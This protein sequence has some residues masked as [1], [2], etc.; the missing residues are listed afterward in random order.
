[1]R[2]AK[3]ALGN[4]SDGKVLDGEF[5]KFG[6][7]RTEQ[8]FESFPGIHMAASVQLFHRLDIGG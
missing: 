6:A 2:R 8:R 3:V 7:Y 5:G 1:M 4:N